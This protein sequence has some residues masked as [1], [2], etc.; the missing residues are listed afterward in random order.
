[1]ADHKKRRRQDN[2]SQPV[3]K[4]RRS[5]G[6]SDIRRN[7]ISQGNKFSAHDPWNIQ[8]FVGTYEKTLHGIQ[9]V[10]SFANEETSTVH[11]QPVDLQN[12]KNSNEQDHTERHTQNSREKLSES[13]RTPKARSDVI[14]NDIFLF[15]AHTSALRCLALSPPSPSSH[16]TQKVIL[17]SGSSDERINL[18]QISN[19]TKP[20]PV[21]GFTSVEGGP[22]VSERF[23]LPPTTGNITTNAKELGSL[24]HHSAPVTSLSCPTH[25]KLLSSALDS[26]L[27]IT[28][29]RD[30]S[31]LTS[32]RTPLPPAKGRPSG[33]TAPLDGHPTGINGFA[34]HPSLK[35]MIT[36]S[37]GERC[38]RL[39]N[40]VTGRKAGA[41]N[42]GREAL[43]AVGVAK[44]E[45]GEA[46]RVVWDGDGEEFA[47]GWERG[48]VVFGKDCVP[49]VKVVV[50]GGT[51]G[52]APGGRKVKVH[53]MRYLDRG[54]GQASKCLAL[55]TD[56]GRVV[57]FSTAE[58]TSITT[59]GVSNG[60]VHA[61]VTATAAPSSKL[62]S[63]SAAPAVAEPTLPS[64]AAL[65]YVDCGSSR[66]KDFKILSRR[67]HDSSSQHQHII[68]TGS[69]D[70]SIAL[71]R[72]DISK[73]LN[74]KVSRENPDTT[75]QVGDLV[76]MYR[77]SGRITCL[78]AM[79]VVVRESVAENREEDGDGEGK[80]ED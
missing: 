8:I 34:V 62:K 3:H 55:S 35:L 36:V 16:S 54:G 44:H 67:L 13:E 73:F 42:F 6:S 15:S 14:F 17:A 75:P 29:T 26:T 71:W 4:A 61:T 58:A 70:G 5:T 80:G 11:P 30:Y 32:I 69:S 45:T 31:L 1:M 57:F 12:G 40:L 9:S 48:A 22:G 19:S 79:E 47:V 20:A 33:D 7:V 65:G 2:A 53:Q 37:K 18:Y 46:M 56:D 10:F 38:M 74:D 21:D 51:D 72:L 43:K 49:K 59:D 39:W 76:G 60:S 64:A 24:L 23:H 78:E 77:T 63:P 27:A 41:L 50:E 66:I 68:I 52:G 28:R 25:G